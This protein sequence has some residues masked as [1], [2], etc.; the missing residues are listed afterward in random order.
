MTTTP[1]PSPEAEALPTLPVVAYIDLNGNPW[2]EDDPDVAYCFGAEALSLR[3][4]AEA[5]IV[6]LR[7]ER[8]Q[9]LAEAREIRARWNDAEN[10]MH[11]EV[12]ELRKE[13][14]ELNDA[15]NAAIERANF[16]HAATREAQEFAIAAQEDTR[17]LDWMGEKQASIEE[18]M[19]NGGEIG[20]RITIID[21][22]RGCFGRHEIAW[23]KTPRSAIDAARASL[24]GDGGTLPADPYLQTR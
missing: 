11:A 7:A 12:A 2:R 22:R 9:A 1:T 3:A 4:P 20:W 19:A 6:A 16:M 21:H 14:D 10:E 23:G 17:R 15:R 8:D 13:R 18:W 24:L 5:A